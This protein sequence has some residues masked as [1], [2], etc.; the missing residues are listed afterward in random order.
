MIKIAHEAPLSIMKKVRERTD[1]C[2]AL[3]HLFE[4]NLE[5]LQF[6]KESLL[7]GREVIL[8]NSIFELGEAFDS[9]RFA[10]W[11]KELKPTKYIIPDVLE[12]G[13]K[14]VNNLI[15]WIEQYKDLP[16]RKM[17]VVQ[18][19]TYEDLV[20]CYLEIDKYCDEIAISFNYS[21]YENLV[22]SGNKLYD[23]CRG[24]QLFIDMLVEDG[25]INHKKSHHL[26]GASIPGEFSY[27]NKYDFIHS[28]DTSNPIIHGIRNIR[29]REWGLDTKES[30]KLFELINIELTE[31]QEDDIDYNIYKFK[32]LV[33]ES[34]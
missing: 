30:V 24:R 26:L 18:G 20:N 19:K 15:L 1:F 11:I 16:G 29:Y 23:W 32:Q 14:T 8:D 25:F 17:G 22:N 9:E 21:Y 5:Y 6:F 12:D 3:V 13:E 7:L 34:R 28:L 31:E 27:Y 33:N 2:Y 10:Y 4:E